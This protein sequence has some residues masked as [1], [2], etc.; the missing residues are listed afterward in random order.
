MV[1]DVRQIATLRELIETSALDHASRTAFVLKKQKQLTEVTYAEFLSDIKA[2]ST[3][4]NAKGFKG[5]KIAV[6]GKNSY[7]WALTYLA[8]ASG[9]GVVVP[10]DKDLKKP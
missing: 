10:V 2:L 6:I 1:Y 8:V 9:V 3:V 4:L 5:K 7:E